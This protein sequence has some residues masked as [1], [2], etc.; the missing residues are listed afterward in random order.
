MSSFL[1]PPKPRP[2]EATVHAA[3]P[4]TRS[5]HAGVGRPERFDAVPTPIVATSTYTFADSAELAAHMTGEHSDPHREEYGRYGN[6]TVRALEQRLAALEDPTGKAEC[7][8]FG[9]GM[10]ALTTTLLALLKQGAHVILFRDGYRRTRQFVVKTLAAYGVEHTI[11][12]PGDLAAVEAAIRPET[13][14]VVGESPTNPYLHC[15]DLAAL[16]ALAKARRIKTVVDSTFATPIDLQ[17]LG[18]GI[19]LVVHS[20]TKYLAGHHDVLA[21]AV[22]GSRAL[23]GLIRD[24]RGVL[25]GVLDPHGAFLVARG[26]KTLAVR[27]ERHDRTAMAVAEML[28]AHPRVAEV[29]Y[30]G[31]VSHPTYAIAQAQMTGFGGVVSFRLKTDPHGQGHESP[32][33]VTSRV[34]DGFQLARIAPSLGGVDT[35]VEQPAIMSY[36]EMT[37]E[38]R[39]AAGI[40]DDLIRLAVGIED[41]ADVLADVQRAL[42]AP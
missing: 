8:A 24:L 36:Y 10:A 20:A 5:V 17:P 4:S 31:L 6:P 2:R 15:T 18:L 16:A 38:Q 11:V 29:F 21:G 39:A 28:A 32:L 35:L 40:A 25:G 41:E 22:V 37:P 27:V 13:R 14:L 42:E 26:L 9:S 1:P 34:V 7:A 33:A 23:V 3:G 30:P 19:D 12:E